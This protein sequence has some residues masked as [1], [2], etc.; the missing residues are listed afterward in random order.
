MGTGRDEPGVW[1]M[2]TSLVLGVLATPVLLALQAKQWA[3]G[4]AARRDEPLKSRLWEMIV[5]RRGA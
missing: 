3:R 1:T 4:A 2:A 5:K